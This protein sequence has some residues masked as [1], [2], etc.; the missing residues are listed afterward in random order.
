M[1]KN[2][3]TL[4]SFGFLVVGDVIADATRGG[5][6]ANKFGEAIAL[7]FSRGHVARFP[8]NH[9]ANRNGEV[10]LT[11]WPTNWSVK[12]Y[13]GNEMMQCKFLD[14]RGVGEL[15]AKTFFES[16]RKDVE[17]NPAFGFKP[18]VV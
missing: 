8:L 2:L 10:R 3:E 4:A 18:T 16:L 1:N 11:E 17:A 5:L 12:W 7:L 9:P 6:T 15:E 13:S 14:G